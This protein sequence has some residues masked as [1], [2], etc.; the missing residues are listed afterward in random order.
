MTGIVGELVNIKAKRE[1]DME[2]IIFGVGND[3]YFL[4]RKLTIL[5]YNDVL[6]KNLCG[7]DYE[8]RHLTM[9]LSKQTNKEKM[10]HRNYIHL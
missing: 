4:T 5:V 10:I 6:H 8:T 1:R 9:F 2:S 3:N 7:I